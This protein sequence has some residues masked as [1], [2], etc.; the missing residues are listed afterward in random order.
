MLK[1]PQQRDIGLLGGREGGKESA[2][3]IEED[4]EFRDLGI[5]S[6]VLALEFNG[7]QYV[8]HCKGVRPN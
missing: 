5:E 8:L 4:L 3:V 7:F 6:L 2:E 1:P